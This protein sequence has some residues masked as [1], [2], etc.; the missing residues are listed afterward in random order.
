MERGTGIDLL[1]ILN[2]KAHGGWLC[3]NSDSSKK[4]TESIAEKLLLVCAFQY[5]ERP[6]RS[7]G[8]NE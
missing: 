6:T 8:K 2:E 1:I 4:G 7:T 3:K 5:N